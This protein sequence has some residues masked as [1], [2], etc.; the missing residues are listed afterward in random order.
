MYAQV[1]NNNVTMLDDLPELGDL[2]RGGAPAAYPHGEQPYG[3]TGHLGNS[4]KF[5]KFIRPPMRTS[6]D[7]GMGSMGGGMHDVG[8]GSYQET[9]G[10]TFDS[11]V[12]F[13]QPPIME[14]FKPYMNMSCIDI[15][16]HIQECPVCSKFYSNDKTVYIIAIVVLAV[17]CLLLLKRVLNV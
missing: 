5:D 15:S 9:Y 14:Q 7:S 8:V 1:R 6:P 16:K 4:N 17:V 3:P 10:P 12:V 13:A 11:P 2:E